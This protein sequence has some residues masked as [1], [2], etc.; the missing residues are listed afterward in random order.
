MADSA[1]NVITICGSLRK[2]SFNAAL[3]RALPALVSPGLSIKPAPAWDKFPVY[4]AD[5]QNSS[6]FPPEVTVWAD[7]IRAAEGHGCATEAGRRAEATGGASTDT[8]GEQT[9]R[10]RRQRGVAQH[11]FRVCAEDGG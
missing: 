10:R 9:G 1:L 7:A 3:A 6:G 8:T 2:G 5:I 4:N 11:Q